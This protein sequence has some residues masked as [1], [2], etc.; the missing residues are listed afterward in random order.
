MPS[1]VDTSSIMWWLFALLSVDVPLRK[2]CPE[3]ASSEG[4]CSAISWISLTCRRGSWPAI[5]SSIALAVTSN[6]II[7]LAVTNCI[8]CKGLHEL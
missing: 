3:R 6:C 7:A 8:S 2:M 4:S 1:R 5:D